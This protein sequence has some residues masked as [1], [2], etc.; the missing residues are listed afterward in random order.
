MATNV[1]DPNDSKLERL[2]GGDP[3][4]PLRP[5]D[6]SNADPAVESAVKARQGFRD[7]P[8]LMV[9]VG[10]LTLAIIAWLAVELIY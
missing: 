8:V 10:G 5:D 7:T 2:Q 6:H 3:I 1:R 4:P 9:L